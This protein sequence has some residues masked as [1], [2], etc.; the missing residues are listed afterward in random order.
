MKD[1]T[2][3]AYNLGDLYRRKGEP[4]KMTE[5]YLNSLAADPGKLPTLQTIFS[6]SLGIEDMTELQTQLYARII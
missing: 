6:R 2:R 1:P 3:F 5:Q 4:V